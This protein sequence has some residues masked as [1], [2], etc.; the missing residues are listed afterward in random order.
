LF[1]DQALG[2]FFS[3][4]P[5]SSEKCRVSASLPIRI[6]VEDAWDQ[7][8]LE[9]PAQTPVA[10]AKRQALAM[11]HTDGDPSAYIVKYRGAPVLDEQRTLAEPASSPTLPSSSWLGAAGPCA[12][13]W[14]VPRA[15]AVC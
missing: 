5:G 12:D 13:P 7:V 8:N 2:R 4:L 1:F 9:L 10:E 15:A 14:L 11:T 6:M 3:T